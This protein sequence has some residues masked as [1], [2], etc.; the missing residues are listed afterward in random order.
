MAA[1]IKNMFFK[2][3]NIL[4]VKAIMFFLCFSLL[5]NSSGCVFVA[6]GIAGIAGGYMVAR[7]TIA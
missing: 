1:T 3:R 2:N 7:D 5:I 4:R 6:G